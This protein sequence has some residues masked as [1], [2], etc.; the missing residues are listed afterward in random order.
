MVDITK[1][2]YICI[3]SFL[4]LMQKLYYY[5]LL[6]DIVK[7]LHYDVQTQSIEQLFYINNQLMNIIYCYIIIENNFALNLQGKANL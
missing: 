7:Y 3:T 1:M 2:F 5:K 6:A 4:E